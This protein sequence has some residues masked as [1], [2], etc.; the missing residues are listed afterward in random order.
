MAGAATVPGVG[1]ETVAQIRNDTYSAR[2]V[3]HYENPRNVGSFNSEDRGIGTGVIGAPAS[4]EVMKLQIKVD[5]A[6]GLIEDARF[7]VYGSGPAIAACSLLTEWVKGKTLE[8]AAALKNS[9]IA[10]ELELPPA[11][12][13]CA[14]AAEDALK[15]AIAD[16]RR[17]NGAASGTMTGAKD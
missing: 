17:K 11:K 8:Q 6:R 7:K 16:Y 15:A 3:D 9:Q 10:R 1:V 12:V 13:H 5:P 14:I 4:G 2:I